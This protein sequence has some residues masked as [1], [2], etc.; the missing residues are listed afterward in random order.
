MCVCIL[1]IGTGLGYT[2]GIVIVGYNFDKRQSLAMGVAVS[3]AGV[4]M[5]TL[6]ALMQ[7]ARDN[8]GD[9]GFFMFLAGV[10]FHLVLFGMVCFP[11]SLELGGQKKRKLESKE[12]SKRKCN[13]TSMVQPYLK[14]GLNKGCLCLCCAMFTYCFGT[15]LL[16]L[17]LPEYIISK[18]FQAAD[19]TFLLALSGVI[20]LIGRFLTG[21]LL[22]FKIFGGM[23]LYIVTMILVA[24]AIGVFPFLVHSSIGQIMCIGSVG[25]FFGSCYVVLTVV[26]LMFVDISYL[27]AAIGFQMFFAGIGTLTGTVIAGIYVI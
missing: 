24:I 14:V 17:H 12:N 5:L 19:G 7:F 11:S 13:I 22:N 27:A 23:F 1:G 6:S 3:G 18:G 21:L 25:L 2:T 9:F 26:T 4:G 15:C 8:Y 16:Y 20:T 10:F